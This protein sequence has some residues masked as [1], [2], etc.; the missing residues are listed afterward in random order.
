MASSDERRRARQFGSAGEQLA[1]DFLL[2]R[3]LELLDAGWHCRL[4]EL[5]L[6]MR[7]HDVLVF[8]EVRARREGSAVSAIDSVDA[9]KQGRFVRAARAWLSRH[10]VESRLPA[11]FD[12][13]AIDGERIDWLRDAFSA[14]AY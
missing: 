7:E 6:V 4:G 3:G 11:R 1:R 9:H 8:V 10:P 2:S 13:V 5:D 12:I 14:P